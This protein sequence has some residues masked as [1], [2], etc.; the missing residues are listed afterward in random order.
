MLT[1]VTCAI[2]SVEHESN[3][4]LDPF[5]VTTSL[6]MVKEHC[7]EKQGTSHCLLL[8]SVHVRIQ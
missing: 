5:F 2:W 6:D 1:V 7:K 8:I 3:E 4:L